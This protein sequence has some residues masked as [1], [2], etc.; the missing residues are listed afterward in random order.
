MM[1]EKQIAMDARIEEALKVSTPEELFAS[2]PQP[3]DAPPED[4]TDV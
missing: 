2:L 4:L 1:I 3:T